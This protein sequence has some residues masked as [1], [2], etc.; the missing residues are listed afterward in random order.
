M[1]LSDLLARAA[2]W[3]RG[4]ATLVVLAGLILMALCLWSASL[5]LGVSTDTDQLF[6]ESLPWRQRQLAMDRAFPQF[7]DTLVAVIDA[8]APEAAEATAAELARR[9]AADPHEFRDATRPDASPWFDQNGLMFLD[10]G[11]LQDLLNQ[12]ID[13]QPFLGQLVADPSARG[14]FAALAL[15]AMGVERGEANLGPFRAALGAFHAALADALAGHPRP[16]SWERLLGGSLVDRAGPYRFVLAHPRLDYSALQPGGAATL[17]MRAIIADLPYVRAGQ[18]RA[19]ITGSVALADEEF[20]TVAQGAAWGLVGSLLLVALWLFLAVR[21]WRL[22]V[23]ILG[24]LLLGLALT[25]GFAALAVGTLNLVSVAFAVLFIGIAVDFSI[26]FS[27]RY[28]SE[29]HRTPD[30]AE[31]L[32]ATARRVGPQILVASAATAAGFLA[33]VPTDF[34]GVAELGL[35]SGV[36]MLV[37][38]V[39]TS[40]FLPAALTLCRPQPEPGEIGF[41]WG[42][43]LERGLLRARLLLLVAFAAAALLGLALLPQLQFDSDPL[44]TK[45]PTTEAMRTLTDLMGS[46][47]TN[48]YSADI[49]APDL[50]AADALATRLRALPLVAEVLTLSSLV[51]ADQPPKLAAIADAADL[52]APT[53]SARPGAAPVDAAA[54][55]EA[56]AGAR[57]ALVQVLPKMAAD[58]PLRALAGDLGGFATAPDSAV[59][60]ANDALVRFL[61]MQLDRLRTALSAHAVTAADMPQALRRDWLLPDGRARVQ[62]VAR[63]GARDSRGLHQFAAE[64]RGIAPDAAGAG[65]IIV[66]T[67]ATIVDAFRT[68]AIAAVAAI[69]VI[70]LLALRRWL[71]LAL[72]LAPLLISALL[73]VV[74]VV[75]TGTPLNFANIIALP[76]LLGVGVSF[77]IYFVMN[78]RAGADAY[79]GTATARAV[80]FS[81][82]T[83]A[84]AFGSLALSRH[85][86]TASMGVLLLTSLAATLLTSL[87]FMPALLRGL[88]RQ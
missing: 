73:T 8:P 37:A 65:V 58:D 14:L 42:H 9:L 32:P 72:V 69:A 24:T 86:G 49:L 13:A 59:L 26:Q 81:A 85:P 33:F 10:P 4:H 74:V 25:T 83:T 17:A 66:S 80:M 48:P 54:V 27:V 56:A 45:D 16:L 75:L 12:T 34:A 43:A 22:I 84:T 46:P 1:R 15:V 28:R 78:W 68:A 6:A 7:R 2:R 52:L 20:A 62:A 67:A 87:L 18:A 50:A 47:L 79:L 53:L 55:R 77:N 41:A 71:D 29:R 31:A 21:T 57:T 70:L 23:P 88:R 30:A 63:S 35:I 36:G 5:R 19:R 82:L 76:L 3:S 64:V 44:H 51:P 39:C 38:F 40:T 11:P 61:P 60:A